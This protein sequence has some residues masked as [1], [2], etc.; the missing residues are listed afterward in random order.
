MTT[1]VEEEKN[2]LGVNT[3]VAIRTFDHRRFGML[4]QKY[5]ASGA[6]SL[7]AL[8]VEKGALPT[9]E[10]M[11]RV[12]DT[13]PVAGSRRIISA[14]TL[15][16]MTVDR[17]LQSGTQDYLRWEMLVYD[18]RFEGAVVATKKKTEIKIARR[19]FI[20]PEAVKTRLKV[21]NEITTRFISA[22]ED[23]KCLR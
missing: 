4:F 12:A 21:T 14:T 9:F 23:N 13:I 2:I 15:M 16:E 11:N 3:L 19:M 22:L 17:L 6:W 10:L 20:H 1:F 18:V 7:P 8:K 5:A